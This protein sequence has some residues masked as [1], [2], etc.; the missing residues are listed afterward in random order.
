MKNNI[1]TI[2]LGGGCF[3]CIEA[4]FQKIK[5]IISL[6]PGYTGGTLENPSYEDVCTGNTGHAEV[7]KIEFDSK[8]ITL[9]KL[10]QIFFLAHDPTTLNRQGGD[11]GTQYRS[12]IL[13]SNEDQKETI[14]NAIDNYKDEVVTEVK[15]LE[16]FYEAEEY[17]KDYYLKN[18]DARYCKLII[19]PKIDKVIG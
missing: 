4:I 2:I 11:V 16:K 13:Y 10:L 3:W 5:G 12:I 6:T 7:V 8:I 9:E 18:E 19:K 14:N 1:Q 15:P 17:H